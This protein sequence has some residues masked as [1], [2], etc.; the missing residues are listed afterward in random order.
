MTN[1]ETTPTY[2]NSDFISRDYYLELRITD[3]AGQVVRAKRPADEEQH[4]MHPLPF[5]YDPV[6]NKVYEEGP[7]SLLA[8]GPRTIPANVDLRQYYDLSIPGR[9]LA[10]VQL[11]AMQF[12]GNTCDV[13]TYL[14]Q[15]VLESN[16]A[17]FYMAGDTQVSVSPNVWPLTWKSAP[18]G[19]NTVTATLTPLTGVDVNQLETRAIYLNNVYSGNGVVDGSALVVTFDGKEAIDS[20]GT[21]E[22][23]K[24]YK[25]RVAGWYKGGSYFGGI[26][27]INVLEYLFQGFF[28][29]VDNLPT[30]NSAKAG[31]AI[32]VKWRLTDAA[33]NPVSDPSSFVSLTSVNLNCDTLAGGTESSIEETSA[34]SSGLQ[35]L[36]DGN[37]QYNWK[38]PKSYANSCRTMQLNLKDGTTYTANFKYKK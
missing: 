7:C 34:G 5:R 18:V 28:S 21:A 27:D 30:V 3:P 4:V 11:S 9:Y 10:Q 33:G 24:A 12:A 6:A 32:P 16:G 25:V 22:R 38:T 37:W 15:G 26:A 2:L 14:W 8:S 23:G 13:G 36:G 1:N 19:T 31:Q 29:P 17:T 20:L 35:Y